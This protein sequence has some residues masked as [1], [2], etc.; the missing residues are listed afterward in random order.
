MKTVS[1]ILELLVL[2]SLAYYLF[3]A[4]CTWAFFRKGKPLQPAPDQK[5][6]PVSVIKPAAG[7]EADTLENFISF[8]NQDYPEYEI[9]FAVSQPDDPVLP[10]LKTLKERF[11][12]KD[13]NWVIVAHNEGPNYKV[14]NLIAAINRTKYN[15]LVISDADMRVKSAYL[16]QVVT[17]FVEEKAGLVTCL[18]RG[19][20]LKGIASALQALTIQADFIPNVLLDHHFK[21]ISYGFGATLCTSK[22]VLS[23]IESFESLRH[24]LADDYQLAHRIHQQGFRI[25]VCTYLI[26]HASNMKSL[27]H[28]FRH[29]LRWAIT[30]RV[31]RPGGYLASFITHGVSLAVLLLLVAGVSWETLAILTLVLGIRYAVIILLNRHVIANEEIRRYFWLIPFKDLSHSV[32]WLLSLRL[33]TV[34]WHHRRFQV[35]KDGKMVELSR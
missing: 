2:C 13:I 5:L 34:R 29:Q 35:L 3:S 22:E 4:Y 9:L 17:T 23:Q 15:V 18:Y 21:G 14:G 25:V 24:Y 33:N 32:I 19:V 7:A 30:Q 10:V 11:P 28:Y 6:P 26:D 1:S 31:S 16:R 8:C 12:D 20:K 27:S